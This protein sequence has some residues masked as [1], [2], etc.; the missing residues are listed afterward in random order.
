MPTSFRRLA[1][2]VAVLAV[3]V[4][5]CSG[6]TR[7][8]V[9]SIDGVVVPLADIV[10]LRS[11][12]PDDVDAVMTD[13]VEFRQ[14]L[15]RVMLEEVNAQAA[16]DDFGIVLT[17]DDIVER[18]NNPPDR[19]AGLL[20]QMGFDPFTQASADNVA[21]LSLYIDR[22]ATERL[23]SE[24]GLVE[25]VVGSAPELLTSACVRHILVSTEEEAE[26]VLGRLDAGEDFGE[27]ALD[28]SIDTASAQQGGLLG[29]PDDCLQPLSQFVPDFANAAVT[30]PIGQAVGPV[31]S[32][33]GLHIILVDERTDPPTEA[34]VAA[35]P[36]A[37]IDPGTLQSFWAEWVQEAMAEK[38]IVVNVL[39]GM[40]SPETFE[41]LPP[42]A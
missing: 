1:V 12:Y 27:V 13:T 2:V 5:A 11:D 8:P 16:A 7:D 41:V 38:D 25:Q 4:V 21:A 36:F 18:R 24:E 37:Y 40:W 6:E 10:A 17:D 26:S 29:P 33:F 42:D 23:N 15:S 28:V 20:A 9:A 3:L 35:D 32:Q 22:V 14:D 39:I 31:P 34:D 19:Y 30:A